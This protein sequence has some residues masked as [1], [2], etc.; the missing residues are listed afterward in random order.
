[1]KRPCLALWRPTATIPGVEFVDM[2]VRDDASV[3]RAI[4]LIIA[5]ARRID[6]LVNSAGGTMLGAV[7]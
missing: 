4:D 1:M 7:E 5:K 6:V 2:D 3:K